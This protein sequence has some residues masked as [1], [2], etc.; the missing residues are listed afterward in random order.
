MPEGRLPCQLLRCQMPSGVPGGI[1]GR[2]GILWTHQAALQRSWRQNR[3]PKTY[4]PQSGGGQPVSPRASPLLCRFS[5]ACMT[6]PSARANSRRPKSAGAR[7]RGVRGSA[8]AATH[9]RAMGIWGARRW[10]R[11]PS[12]SVRADSFALLGGATGRLQRQESSP[13]VCT[14]AILSCRGASHGE[15]RRG[16]AKPSS[17]RG[18]QCGLETA[19]TAS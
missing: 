18:Q 19:R 7:N 12:T 3:T 14:E 2:D 15:R 11:V 6:K 17:D 4:P 10:R 9:P 1:R 5:D 13:P 16:R 8:G